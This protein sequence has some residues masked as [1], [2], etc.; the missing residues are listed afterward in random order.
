MRGLLSAPWLR[1]RRWVREA[2]AN[3]RRG[4]R[5]YL[6][7]SEAEIFAIRRHWG[8]L[9][10]PAALFLGACLVTGTVFRFMPAGPGLVKELLIW[11]D[12]L[13]LGYLCWQ[14]LQWTDERFVATDQ[15]VILTQGLLYRRV[16]TLPLAKVTDLSY[17]RSVPGRLFGYGTFVFES[18]GQDQAMRRV[19]WMPW[20]D[21]VYRLLVADMFHV[22]ADPADVDFILDRTRRANRYAAPDASAVWGDEPSA[23]DELETGH[24]REQDYSRAV[25][26][27]AP[28]PTPT[29]EPETLF[30]S[31]DLQA[32][33]SSADTGPVRYVEPD[34]DSTA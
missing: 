6:V 12:A 5:R 7:P 27:H 26:V 21:V 31:E 3:Y 1:L 13:A 2:Q 24:E 19:T 17:E 29:R 33:R 16:G 25:P 32:R 8:I 28:A 4:Y 14:L 22:E 18:A 34:R 15:R 10:P 30:R 23:W 20:P 9:V 11:A